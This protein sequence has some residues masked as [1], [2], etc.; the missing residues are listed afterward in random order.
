VQ[1]ICI[2]SRHGR[3]IMCVVC[4]RQRIRLLQHLLRIANGFNRRKPPMSALLSLVFIIICSCQIVFKAY[5]SLYPTSQH[6][7]TFQL[8]TGHAN[9]DGSRKTLQIAVLE[10]QEPL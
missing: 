4:D 9:L 2:N 10:L 1:C 6:Y 3:H 5:Y 7:D 8:V